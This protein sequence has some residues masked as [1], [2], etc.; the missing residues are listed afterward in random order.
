[1]L[2][3]ERWEAVSAHLD[4]A[5]DMADP[6]RE[7]YLAEL[8]RQ[9][10]QVAADLEELLAVRRAVDAAGFLEGA[11]ELPPVPAATLAGQTFGA[12]TVVSQIGEGGMGSVWLARRSDGRFEGEAALK[13]LNASFIGRA[14]EERFKREGSILARLAHPH[15]ARLVDAGVSPAGQPYL[16][17]EHV[18]GERIDAYC[19]GRGA[20]LPARLVLFLEVLA[21]VA[22]AHANLIVH[23]DIKPSNVL[24]GSDGGVKLLDFGIAKLIEEDGA[25]QA[26]ELTHE[27]GRAMTPEYAAPEQVTGGAITTATDVY[28]LGIL[29]YVLLTGR[30]PAEAD[31]R[32]TADLVRSIVEIE[33]RRPSDAVADDGRRR[34]LRGDLDTIVLRALKKNPQER[35]PS[36]TALAEDV[37]RY[38]ARKPISARPDTLAYRAARFLQRHARAVAAAAAVAA[39][40]AGLIG[41]YTAR[42]AAERDRA[43]IQARKAEKISELLTGLLT[44]ADPYRESREPTVRGILDAGAARVEEELAG[45]PELQAEM[46]TVMG[47]VYERLGDPARAQPLLERA[48]ALGRKSRGGPSPRVAQ[49]LNDLGVLLREKGNYAAAGPMLEEAAAMRTKLFGRENGEVGVT[50]VELGRVWED[51]GQDARAEPLYREALAIRRKVLGVE[52]HETA[53]SFNELALLLRRKGDLAEAETLFR[54]VLEIDR[55]TRGE[56]H[57]DTAT[58]YNNLALIA[59]DRGD[60]PE[61]ER[62]SRQ[63]LAISRRTLGDDHPRVA[64][65]WNTLSSILREERRYDEALDAIREAMRL[66]AP[67]GEEHPTSVTYSLNL[68]RLQLVRGE[69]KEA[70]PILRRA[71]AV[72]R[73]TFPAGDWR[74]AQ[75]ES[76]LG[77][78]LVQRGSYEEAEGLLK[79]AAANLKEGAGPQG[80]EAAAN[81]ERLESLARVRAR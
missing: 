18:E 30:H 38:L 35:Y 65:S 19:D 9:R 48:V 23:R 12:Y 27:G 39:L 67:L 17:L 6:E 79:G 60:Y 76:L 52:D 47:R 25:G 59:M 64:G 71:V 72:R 66:T 78:A 37:R 81:R 36:V 54:Q 53:T 8:R 21:A 26:T 45:E 75:A 61:A 24:V 4:D 40:L 70:E 20:G 46:L 2:S 80:S 58:A 7:A 1:M 15:I 62:L 33:P 55:K 34:I 50:L 10:P 11:V 74:T 14:G 32:S 77:E 69:W 22:H 3:R 73:K 31:R 13:L 68:A 42:L 51:Q 44:G 56:E 5:M 41:F 16:V 49:S 29:L 28:A 63:G 43:R 57:P